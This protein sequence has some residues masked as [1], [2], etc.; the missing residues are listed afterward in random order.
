[1]KLVIAYESDHKIYNRTVSDRRNTDAAE[2]SEIF[3]I[4][5]IRDFL[6][7]ISENDVYVYIVCI[8]S[9]FNIQNIYVFI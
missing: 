8:I 2:Y 6:V 7:L 1:M 9:I 4:I 3:L 5:F